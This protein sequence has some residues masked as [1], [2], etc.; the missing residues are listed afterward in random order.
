VLKALGQKVNR[1]DPLYVRSHARRNAQKA[2]MRAMLPQM[3]R[4][5]DAVFDHASSSPPKGVGSK[6]KH[7]RK[8]SA[9]ARKAN[10]K[11]KRK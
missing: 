8:A 2:E 7:K 11:K 3:L 1:H 6:I 4:A 9:A 10:K 5:H